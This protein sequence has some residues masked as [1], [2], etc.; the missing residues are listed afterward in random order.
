[1]FSEFYWFLDTLF[2]D[3][4]RMLFYSLDI[5]GSDGLVLRPGTSVVTDG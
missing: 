5:N 1:M 3:H 2:L 4:F